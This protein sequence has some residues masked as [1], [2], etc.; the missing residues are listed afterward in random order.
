MHA[1]LPLLAAKDFPLIRHHSLDAL[2]VN[3]GCKCNQRCLQCRMAASPQPTRKM[4]SDTIA[5]VIVVLQARRVSMLDLT[6][7]AP[8]LDG[9]FRPPV[10]Q[11]HMLGVDVIDR[12][13]R[14]IPSE[15]G[16][17][18]LAA[19]L[20]E[21]RVKVTAS[22]PRDSPAKVDRQRGE[23]VLDRSIAGLRQ[24]TA[25]GS[26]DRAR[27]RV[28]DRICNPQ[29]AVLLP[30]RGPLEAD[31]DRELLQHFGIR[32]GHLFAL[33]SVP[34]QRFG[35]T[36]VVKGTVGTCMQLL[37]ESHR[38][39]NQETVL[40]RSLLSVDRQGLLY[41]CGFNQMLGLRANVGG[42]AGAHAGPAG[43]ALPHRRDLL[44]HDPAATDIRI[45]DHCHGCT[46]GQ[47][48]SRG[49]ALETT[50]PAVTQTA[51]VRMTEGVR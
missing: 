8:A 26:G 29:S 14:T 20:A 35:S 19:L 39:E 15:P 21:Q 49:R 6:G 32:F 7:G 5:L 37:R 1:T 23:G 44:E 4:D 46:A 24:L 48:S 33:T 51:V 45:A 10:R 16:Q 42:Q 36:L 13:N 11:A 31:H 18:G 34:V 43:P 47:G 3:P 41:D 12:C 50:A 9:H 22:L 28:L 30:P 40:C 38:A 2:Q 25:L 17:E 27:G